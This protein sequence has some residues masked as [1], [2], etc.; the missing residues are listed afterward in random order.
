VK[1]AKARL[2]VANYTA[3]L[4]NYVC[5]EQM[6]RFVS[7]SRPVDWRPIDVV[8]TALVYENGKEQYRDLTINGKAVKKGMEELSGA[9]ST[10][11][12]GTMTADL[13]SPATDADF[14]MI[15]HTTIAGRDAAV[16]KFAV[17]QEHSHWRVQV[18]GQTFMPAYKGSVWIDDKTSQVLRVE[19][20]AVQVPKAFPLDTVESA[21]DYEFTRIGEGQFLLP[22]HAETLSCVR[23]TSDCSRNVIDF[24]NY[25][26]F[27]GESKITFD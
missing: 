23:G 9:W 22:V 3:Y 15:R 4:P 7:T 25:H 10:G 20:Q 27:S 2:A 5:H 24:R 19:M 21:V 1:L 26:K 13:F 17:D 11:E 14:Q 12:F 16:F 18:P 6:A 8:A